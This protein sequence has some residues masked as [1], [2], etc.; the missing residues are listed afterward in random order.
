[1]SFARAGSSPAFGTKFSVCLARRNK[2]YWLMAGK[3]LKASIPAAILKWASGLRFPT[4]FF[5]TLALFGL[6]LFIP[7]FIPFVDEILLGMGALLLAGW[8]KRRGDDEEAE[9]PADS[10]KG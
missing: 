6:D 4:L 1:M 7:D 10:P 8:R 3:L 5:V 9:P 2:W